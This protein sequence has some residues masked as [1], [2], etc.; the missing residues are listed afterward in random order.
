[1]Q[2]QET[3]ITITY[4]RVENIK[5][6]YY[7]NEKLLEHFNEATVL[8]IPDD[9]PLEIPRIIIKSLNE[10]A[11]L[12]I[13][14]IATTLDVRYDNGYEK[15]WR[16][17][18]EYLNQRIVSIFN[19][20]DVITD[21]DYKYIGLV[22]SVLF[23]D[24]KDNGAER[25]TNQLLNAEKMKKLYDVNIKYTFVENENIFVNIMLQNARIYKS[26]LTG[27]KSGELNPSN[28]I[29]ESIGAVID[30]NDRKGF[31]DKDDY[32][33]N[34]DKLQELIK[35]MDEVVTQKIDSLVK[36]GVYN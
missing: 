18:S 12:N 13:S 27:N 11:Q 17:C 9:A 16:K 4:N 22:S 32:R 15:E 28:Q 33:S 36:K 2:I 1:M 8:P 7:Q 30:I 10:H 6:A 19:L 21:Q 25:L 3:T 35:C 24:I 5:R 31:N 26:A 23:D 20:L 29:A 34:R 14:P